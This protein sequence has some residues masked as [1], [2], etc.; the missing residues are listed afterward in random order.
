[1]KEDAKEAKAKMRMAKRTH[2]VILREEGEGLTQTDVSCLAD[3]FLRLPACAP[4]L[5]C[6]AGEIANFLQN[7]CCT[8]KQRRERTVKIANCKLDYGVSPSVSSA[9]WRTF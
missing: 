8:A 9:A 7:A 5:A 2:L 6:L 4:S 1:M 3:A